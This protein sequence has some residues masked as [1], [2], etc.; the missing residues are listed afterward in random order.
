MTAK[1]LTEHQERVIGS[2]LAD[3]LLLKRFPEDRNRFITKHGT[4][5]ATGV[6]RTIQWEISRMVAD[7][8]A[9]DGK[10]AE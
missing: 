5:T 4:K 2:A 9:A 1:P 6:F 8:A 7:F 3:M 10:E